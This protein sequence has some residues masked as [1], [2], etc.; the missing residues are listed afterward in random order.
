M[1]DDD[2]HATP[3]IVV[4]LLS[5]LPTLLWPISTLLK[6]QTTSDT[7]KTP[8]NRNSRDVSAT[9]LIRNH[10][11]L[12]FVQHT[13]KSCIDKNNFVELIEIKKKTAQRTN[14]L[15]QR[16][17]SWPKVGIHSTQQRSPTQESYEDC[18]LV[19][20]SHN[21]RFRDKSCRRILKIRW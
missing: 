12:T 17:N 3:C 21:S 8:C 1:R 18:N 15:I 13:C 5:N 7:P 9:I 4:S 11:P 2:R 14:L 20:K 6:Q 10:H 16:L 19:P